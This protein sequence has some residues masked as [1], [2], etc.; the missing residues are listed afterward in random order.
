MKVIVTG[1]AG[2]LGSHLCE[3]LIQEGYEV[4]CIDNLS[5]GSEKNIEHLKSNSKFQ[6]LNHNVVDPLPEDLTA[7]Q[8][9]HLAS[10]ASPNKDNPKVI[11]L[12]PLRLCRLIL[13]E[14]GICAKQLPR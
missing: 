10:P 6:F 9:Y 3:K 5:T 12:C 8:I 14:H 1:G 4:I 11:L 13:W 2:F 7:N